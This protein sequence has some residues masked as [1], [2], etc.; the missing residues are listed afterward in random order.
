MP[1]YH[2]S[3]AS[4]GDD[5]YYSNAGGGDDYYYSDAVVMTTYTTAVPVVA[6]AA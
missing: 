2:Y 1:S 3:D 5:D 4:G 6:D